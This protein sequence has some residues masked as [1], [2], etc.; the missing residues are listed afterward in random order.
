MSWPELVIAAMVLAATFFFAWRRTKKLAALKPGP[1]P[2]RTRIAPA[3]PPRDETLVAT[4]QRLSDELAPLAEKT[5][6][7]RELAELPQFKVVVATFLRSDV[8]LDML[9][10]YACGANWPLACA[11]L[12]ALCPHPQRN[13][14]FQ[15]ILGQLPNIRPWALY[16]ALKYICALDPRPPVGAPIMVSPTWWPENLVIPDLFRE[17]LAAREAL[18]DPPSFGGQLGSPASAPTEQIAALLEKIEHAFADCLLME[19]RHWAS[20]R[21]DRQFLASFGRFWSSAADSLLV[22]PEPWRAALEQAESAVL[23]NPPRSI[24]VTGD[25]RVGKSSFLRLLGQRLGGAGWTVFEASGAELQAGQRYIGELEGRIRQ[26]VE[27]LNVRK[28]VAWYAGDLLQIA[29]SGTHSGQTASIL[30][31]IL[32]AIT[33]GRLVILSEAGS[34]AASRLFQLRPSMRSLIEICRIEPMTEEQAGALA[35]EVAPRI[36]QQLGLRFGDDA[37]ATTLELAQQY[38]GTG[39]LPGA[40]IEL[41]TRSA[42]RAVSAK[43]SELKP[44]GVLDTL[45]Q[46]TGL[47]RSIL[48]DKE[49]IELKSVKQFFA[50]RVMG[51]DEAIAAVVDRIAMLKAGLV[52]PRRPVAVFL[53]AGPTGTGKTEL[54]KTLAEFLFGSSDRMTRLDMSEFQT[55]EATAKILGQRGEGPQPESLIERIRKQP[56]S[57]VLLDEFEKAHANTW[58]LFLQIFDDGRLTDANGRVADFRHTFIVLTSNLGA[59]AH[60]GGGLGFLPDVGAY[61]EDQVLRAVGQTFR[62]EF[63]NRIDKIIVF[64]PLSRDLMRTILRKELNALLERRGLRRR[65][66]AVE[67]EASAIEFLLDRGF[68]PEMGARPL[69]RA[70]DQHVLAPLAATLVEHRFPEGDQFLFVRSNGKAIEVEFVDPDAETIPLA[71]T[72]P[73]PDPDPVEA[74]SLAAMIL[75]PAGTSNERAA[76]AQCWAEIET[77][78]AS[79]DWT[80]L[81]ER[82]NAESAE[83]GFWSRPDRHAVFAR[84]ALIDRVSEA[85]RTAAHLKLR[86]D[87]SGTATAQT[88]R[89]LVARLALQLHLVQQGVTDAL[90]GA[91]VDILLIAEPALDGS[92]DTQASVAWCARLTAMYRQWSS[93]RHMQLQEFGPS[94]GAGSTILQVSGFGAF[95]TLEPEAGLHILEEAD[96]DGGRTVARVRSV[97]GPWEEPRPTD[98]YRE[99]A[100]LLKSAGDSS[101]LVRRYRDG[102]SPLVRDVK[103]GWRSG[104][105]G[106]VLAGDFDLIGTP[107]RRLE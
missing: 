80:S 97:A 28:Q 39:Q 105:L 22:E 13:S 9:H 42:V 25:P 21:L 33:G 61:S 34:A 5:A 88:S 56:F 35:G 86:F 8:T 43:Q 17:Y 103:T 53:F 30:D 92:A 94:K 12:L 41:L 60:R 2:S 44:D 3:L 51:Q 72:P 74:G 70:I 99:F 10:R 58:D 55:A 95:R 85:A 101:T 87:R 81:K 76:L 69:K 47:P 75:R 64:K 100:R 7:P 40:V 73:F 82:L 1:V 90:L 27:E 32:P 78:L 15:T 91:P 54:A 46:I 49:R 52:D 11:A 68:S 26:L 77:Q 104:R 79:E 98:A 106:A 23:H 18:G 96:E 19:L 83:P 66:W 67:W 24:V 16:F 63:V 14:L 59:T 89:E 93:R 20:L 84:R 31:Q 107:Q 36:E 29:I 62:P 37:V 48:D 4:L 45:S 65:D 50:D 102:P 38:L 57:V 6:H 71:P